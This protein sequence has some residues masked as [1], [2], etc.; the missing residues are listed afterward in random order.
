MVDVPSFWVAGRRKLLARAL[1]NL[2]QAL[3]IALCVTETFFKAPLL[4]KALLIATL[5]MSLALALLTWP[6]DDQTGGA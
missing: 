5:V 3:F 4:G 2:F 1:M 6:S